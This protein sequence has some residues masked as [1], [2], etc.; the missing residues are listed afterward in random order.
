MKKIILF[1]VFKVSRESTKTV[2]ELE[3][4]EGSWYKRK[5]KRKR[6]RSEGNLK[7]K[8]KKETKKEARKMTLP[9]K[10]LGC[11]KRGGYTDGRVPHLK[12]S[13]GRFFLDS[14]ASNFP[15][16][17]PDFSPVSIRSVFDIRLV[18]VVV[19]GIYFYLSLSLSALNRS[20]LMH[21]TNYIRAKEK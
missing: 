17:S 18:V 10:G 11:S 9:S 7:E 19:L 13:F 14:F 1:Q 12:F 21:R 4:T 20:P 6:M 3:D 15:C 2:R 5:R 8:M 16:R